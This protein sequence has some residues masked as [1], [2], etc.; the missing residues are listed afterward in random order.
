MID[1]EVLHEDEVHDT[2]ENK[3]NELLEDYWILPSRKHYMLHLSKIEISYGG[4]VLLFSLNDVP[5][6]LVKFDLH[7]V[8]S[9]SDTKSLGSLT[10]FFAKILGYQ[11]FNHTIVDDERLQSILDM[12]LDEF[13]LLYKMGVYMPN[14]KMFDVTIDEESGFDIFEGCTNMDELVQWASDM[15]RKHLD[16]CLGKYGLR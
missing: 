6:D 10:R 2:E 13:V 8:V 7:W 14:I 11:D 16:K 1:E 3:I 9:M 15:K 4:Y 5:C 12:L